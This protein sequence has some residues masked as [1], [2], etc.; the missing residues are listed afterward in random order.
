[1]HSAPI[2]H[3]LFLLVLLGATPAL[4]QAPRLTLPDAS[5]HASVSQ[6]VGLTDITIDYHRPAVGKRKIW[7][8]LVPYD[9]P[10]RAGANEN[11]TLTFPSPVPVGGKQ[12]PA[13]RYVF[14]ISPPATTRTVALSTV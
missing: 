8:A 2:C 1:M 6:R 14:H 9:E 10:W 4:A 3:R 13:G 11:T 5:P 7:G 12:L